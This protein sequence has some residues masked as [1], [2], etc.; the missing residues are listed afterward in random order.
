MRGLTRA[1]AAMIAVLLP[2][3]ALAAAAIDA[4]P[5]AGAGRRVGAAA[6]VQ[7]RVAHEETI[8]PP[9]VVT[10]TVAPPPTVPVPQVTPTAVPRSTTTSSPRPSTPTSITLPP[11]PPWGSPTTT[12]PPVTPTDRWSRTA[13]GVTVTL[14]MEPARPAAGEPVTF[15]VDDVST[16]QEACC[17]VHL[18]LGDKSDGPLIGTS[19]PPLCDKPGTSRTGLSLTHTYAQPGAYEILLMVVTVP[20]RAPVDGPPPITGTQIRAC[21]AVGPGTAEPPRCAP[22]NHFDPQSGLVPA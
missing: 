8:A 3:G 13:N 18:S 2:A 19:T 1:L 4:E 12:A 6:L 11:L 9:V 10:S 22:F 20:C 17:I 15:F 7:D 14:R 21:I 16:P 5:G